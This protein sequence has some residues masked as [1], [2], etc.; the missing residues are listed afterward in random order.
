MKLIRTQGRG[1]R[2]AREVLAALENRGGAAFERVL[3]VVNR[4]VA[5]VRRSGDHALLRYATKFDGLGDEATM[6]ISPHEMA[7]AWEGIDPSLREA[8][9]T[10]AAQIHGFAKMQLPKSWSKSSTAGLTVGQL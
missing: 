2:Q 7:D 1:A 3:P 6:R 5:S 4:I 10:A 9:K 8:L